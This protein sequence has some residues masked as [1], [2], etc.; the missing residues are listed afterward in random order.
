MNQKRKPA[1]DYSVFLLNPPKSKHLSDIVGNLIMNFGA[2]ECLAYE[3]IRHLATDLSEFERVQKMPF[4]DRIEVI[5][6]LIRQRK[7]DEGLKKESLEAWAGALK[8]SNYRDAIACNP[9][10]LGW[11]DRTAKAE[12]DYIGIPDFRRPSKKKLKFV[13]FT[14]F[15]ELNAKIYEIIK[16]AIRLDEILK[17]LSVE[18]SP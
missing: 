10:V 8:L 17:K 5:S 9:I 14:D 12:P 3:W 15:Q 11:R 7:V 1:S 16:I 18:H 2:V 6:S 13:P 4:K